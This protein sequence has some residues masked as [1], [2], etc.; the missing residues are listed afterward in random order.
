MLESKLRA[1]AQAGAQPAAR[2]VPV[3]VDPADEWT[4][5]L[6]A[7]GFDH[8][9]PTAWAAEGLLPRL[10]SQAQEQL[11]GSID[12]YSG[13]GS[14]IAVETVSS[15][16]DHACWLCTRLWEVSSTAIPDLMDRYHRAHPHS[17]D[18]PWTHRVFLDAA[19][20]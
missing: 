5:A 1:L 15:G 6:T 13:R 11:L 19:K 12:L 7:A 20:L 9:E 2:H 14:R 16:P 18:D 4:K 3:P 10:S 17:S 8:N